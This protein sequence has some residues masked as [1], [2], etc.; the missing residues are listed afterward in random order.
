MDW[1]TIL[2]LIFTFLGFY[3]LTLFGSIFLQNRKHMFE[4]FEPNKI[5]SLSVVIPC[6]NGA[7]VIGGTIENLI[8]SDYKGLKKIIVVDHCSTD[9]SYDVI[10]KYAKR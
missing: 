6:Y 7:E 4:W 8:K 10:K 5:Y 3:Y 9:N 1:L 2:Y